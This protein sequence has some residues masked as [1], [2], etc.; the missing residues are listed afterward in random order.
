M[1]KVRLG[2]IGC[3]MIVDMKFTAAFKAVP[4]IEIKSVCDL[5][6]EK[7]SAMR[8]K[9]GAANYY[10][11]YNEM[12][13]DPE[14]DAVLVTTPHPYHAAPVVAC[15]KAGKHILCEKPMAVS[16]AEVD[17]M[18]E[19]ATEN[20]VKLI[21]MPFYESAAFL[22]CKRA[23]EEDWIGPVNSAE[24]YT[25]NQ[26]YPPFAWYLSKQAGVGCIADIGIYSLTPLMALMGP[27]AA[28]SALTAISSPMAT[29]PNGTEAPLELEDKA[30]IT[31]KYDD[32]RLATAHSG[33]AHGM[34]GSHVMLYGPKGA[35][36]L[37][38]WGC[39]NLYYRPKDKTQV[40]DRIK[41]LPVEKR[42]GEEWFKVD[43]AK[44][45]M[46][47]AAV[48]SLVEAIQDNRDLSQVLQ[49]HRSVMEIILKGYE[50]AAKGGCPVALDTKFS[51]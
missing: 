37:H 40:Q 20:K 36:A 17:A 28:V 5:V 11:D 35:L 51:L 18:I 8:D 33:W 29:L 42:F 3:G 38:G 49:M 14:I 26:G 50:S 24:V 23:V 45:G 21:V 19:A 12:L 44:I 43:S 34:G 27:A 2:I 1:A 39:D 4:E 13:A 48:R 9:L 22:T 41:D 46:G 32:G 10:T 7:A 6:E 15:A 47:T 25:S 30:Q 16:L 31:L